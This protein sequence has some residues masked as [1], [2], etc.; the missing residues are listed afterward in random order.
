M[1]DGWG[2]G[3]TSTFLDRWW[4]ADGWDHEWFAGSVRPYDSV[5]GMDHNNLPDQGDCD[6][7]MN[8][9]KLYVSVEKSRTCKLFVHLGINFIKYEKMEKFKLCKYW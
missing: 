1:Y 9:Y 3:C 5:K 2:P 7:E 8:D 4:C 6:I